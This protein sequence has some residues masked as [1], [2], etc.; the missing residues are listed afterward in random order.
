LNIDYSL[1][2]PSAIANEKEWLAKFELIYKKYGGSQKNEEK[3][4]QKLAKK[5]GNS[6]RLLVATNR[7][8]RSLQTARKQ[9]AIPSLADI[10]SRV[11]TKDES[12]FKLTEKER[13]SGIIDFSSD[14][15]DPL[16]ALTMK[17]EVVFQK[18]PYIQNAPRLDNISKARTVLADFDPQRIIKTLANNPS[19]NINTPPPIKIKKVPILTSLA[20]QFQN[21]PLSILYQCHIQKKR[22]RVL[23]RYIDCIRG[24]L[25]GYVLAF[26]KHLNMILTDVEEV[27]SRR[28]TKVISSSE[29]WKKSEIEIFRRQC[30]NNNISGHWKG[31]NDANKGWVR[32]RYCSQLL[33]RGDNVVMV[34]RADQEKS[35]PVERSNDTKTKK[36]GTPGSLSPVLPPNHPSKSPRFRNDSK[37]KYSHN[38]YNRKY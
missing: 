25:T 7:D 32:Q 14:Q 1:I 26:D 2:S 8:G 22:I 20:S 3:L 5:Y 35:I 36:V 11:E 27:Y 33:V 4:S 17:E 15:F 31:E 9:K 28:M 12:W 21:G 18:N 10:M 38:S 6:V 23:I 34:W 37:R 30:T 24:T 29:T 16:A 13:N 19:K